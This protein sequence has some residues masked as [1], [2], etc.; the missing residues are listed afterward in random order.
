MAD[1]NKIAAEVRTKGEM[2]VPRKDLN[3]PECEELHR[4]G[5]AVVMDGD[6]QAYILRSEK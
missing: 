1:L 5:I 3:I 6:R 2:V 4:R